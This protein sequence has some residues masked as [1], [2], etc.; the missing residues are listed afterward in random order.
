MTDKDEP[1]TDDKPE[2]EAEGSQ[3][4]FL[5]LLEDSGFFQQ[6]NSLEVSLK[7]IADEMK[8]F[9]D[10]TAARMKETENLAVHVL[11]IESLLAV[12]LKA[13][14]ISADE[15]DGE[16]KDRTAALSGKPDGSSTVRALALDILEKSKD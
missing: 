10:K 7:G 9:G 8:S 15:L 1:K 12:M 5:D 4:A 3:R 14:P 11:A 16:I 13:Y 6:I 2:T